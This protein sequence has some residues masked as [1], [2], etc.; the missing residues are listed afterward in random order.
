MSTTEEMRPVEQWIERSF[1]GV[2]FDSFGSYHGQIKFSVPT[3]SMRR[4]DDDDKKRIQEVDEEEQAQELDDDRIEAVVCDATAVRFSPVV[5]HQDQI[6][7]PVPVMS[8]ISAS[9]ERRKSGIGALLKLLED[10][11]DAMGLE[12]C[13][14][15]A[16]TLDQMFLNVVTEDNVVEEGYAAVYGKKAWRWWRF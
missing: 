7:T 2:R 14:V 4:E 10:N 16:T 11:K 9:P 13:N 3:V 1:V 8:G 15:W 6:K 5:G 12:S